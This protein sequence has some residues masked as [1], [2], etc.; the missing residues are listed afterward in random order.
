MSG[1]IQG[2]ETPYIGSN[3]SQEGSLLLGG[4]EV[5]GT[6]M[7]NTQEM[8]AVDTAGT[9]NEAGNQTR[10]ELEFIMFL[11]MQLGTNRVKW[12]YSMNQDFQR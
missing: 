11:E 4:D 3:M 8:P 12:I 6:P 10:E 2:K 9:Q 5:I 7:I 1:F